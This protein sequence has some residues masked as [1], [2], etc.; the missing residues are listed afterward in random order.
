MMA[1]GRP[2]A[3]ENADLPPRMVPRRYPSGAVAYYYV[4]GAKRIPLGRDLARARL[5]WAKLE[6]QAAGIEGT[7]AAAVEDWRKTELAKRGTYTQKQ[8]EK[9]LDELLLAFGHIPLDAITTV[10]C[11]NYLEKR[12][13]KVK[14][15]RETSLFSTIFNWCRRTGRTVA[16]NPLPGVEKNH[17]EPR[18]VYVSDVEFYRARESEHATEW[19]RD[20]IG[21]LLHGGQRPGDTLAMTWAHEIDGC[22]WVTQAKTGAKVR[23]EIEGEFKAVLDRI[24]S[25][26]R[27]VK[28]LY[29]IADE[30]GQRITVDRLQKVHIKCRGEM[31]WQ[32]RDIRKKTGTDIEE[33]RHAQALL[34]HASEQ[35]T[36]RVYRQ[37]KGAKVKPLR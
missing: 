11:Q 2:K 31:T 32:V 25:R 12:T 13:A 3:P 21:L 33:I 18:K 23:I 5:E 20:A 7:F 26:P 29:I 14:A 15:N 8:Y 9:Y 34:G 19:Y 30:N 28:S 24:R 6:N 4:A 22:I 17:E 1:M 37:V 16:P 36:A 10:H 27:K 35:T